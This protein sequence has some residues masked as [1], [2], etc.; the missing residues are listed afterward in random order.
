MYNRA[1][2]TGFTQQRFPFKHVY[3]GV[4]KTHKRALKIIGKKLGI[5]TPLTMY[6]SIR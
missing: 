1:V 4:D 5:I 3:T 2:D 6:V